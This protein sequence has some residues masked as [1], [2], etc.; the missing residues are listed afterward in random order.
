MKGNENERDLAR[1]IRSQYGGVRNHHTR[2]SWLRRHIASHSEKR[3]SENHAFGFSEICFERFRFLGNQSGSV[4]AEF[5]VILPT[6]M[7]I[8]FLG[9]QILAIQSGR[10]KLISLAT[11]AARAISRGEDT[12]V[13]DELLAERGIRA[14]V[15]VQHL[16]QSICVKALQ[17]FRVAGFIG[18]PIEEIQCARKSGL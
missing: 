17:S 3:G 10:M 6:V 18:F 11:D 12:S 8:L 7:T 5:A 14:T 16:E 15:D 4:T 1:R 13:I 9:I 2:G